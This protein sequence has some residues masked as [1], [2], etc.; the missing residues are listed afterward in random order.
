MVFAVAI[1]NI[2][3]T[4]SS[5]VSDGGMGSLLVICVALAKN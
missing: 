4:I 1:L 5:Y 3:L 2:A